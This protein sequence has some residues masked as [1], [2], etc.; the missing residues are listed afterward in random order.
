MCMEGRRRA[1]LD[2]A[3]RGRRD[4][5][6]GLLVPGRLHCRMV[7]EQDSARREI[8]ALA[9]RMIADGGLDYAS[10]KAKAAR[11]L[12]GGRAPRGAIPDNDAV[13]E[14]LREHL[15][16][17]DDGHPARVA[18]LRA[19]ALRLMTDLADFQ[20]LVTGAAWK[21]IAAEHAPVHLQLFHDNAKEVEFWLLN[22][23]IGF[24]VGTLPHF[25]GRGEVEA[26]SLE[27][28]DVPV[29]LS[30][31]GQDD[32]RGAL[33]GGADAARGDRAA[34]AARAEAAGAGATGATGAAG[35]A[36]TAEGAGTA[37]KIP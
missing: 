6:R 15:E 34:M 2:A 18:R 26:L 37:G 28:D 11:E 5:T 13:D 9:A 8:A 19:T 10:A 29:L 24:D 30:L 22:R 16:L 35:A 12:F 4:C 27:V 14:A 25:G 36:G 1:A 31:Y 32:L 7:T 20:P 3:L 21:G 33:R 23:R 17:F